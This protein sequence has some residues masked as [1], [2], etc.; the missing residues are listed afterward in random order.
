MLDDRLIKERKPAGLP[1]K[2][3]MPDKIPSSTPDDWYT[4]LFENSPLPM[5]IYDAADGRIL[6]ANR[7]ACRRYGYT[8]QEFL[9]M[10]A[11]DLVPELHQ[12]VP[13]VPVAAG[14]LPGLADLGIRQQPRKDGGSLYA[15]LFLRDLQ[16][17]GHPAKCLMAL[18]TGAAAAAEV[19]RQQQ[20]LAEILDTLPLNIYLKNPTGE[21]VLLNEQAAQTLG[22]S[23][24]ELIGK[25]AQDVLPP[26]IAEA[27]SQS[28]AAVQQAAGQLH[29]EE[30]IT[31]EE[32]P[33]TMLAG[34][35]ILQEAGEQPFLLSYSIDITERKQFEQ[36]VRHLANY[37]PLTNLPN[38]NLLNDRLAQAVAHAH[39]FGRQ[40]AV[41]FI[42]IDRFKLVNDSLGHEQGDALLKIMAAR[43][44]KALPEGD[45]LAR[46]AGDDFAATLLDIESEERVT[47]TAQGL[48]QAIAQPVQLENHELVIS[49]SIGISLYPRDGLTPH[50]LL[51]NADIAMSQCKSVGGNHFRF[52]AKEMNAR[53]F[54]RLLLETDLR[55]ALVKDEFVLHYQPKVAL[56]TGRIVGLEALIRWQH[57]TRGLLYPAKFI[58]VA[59]EIGLIGAL[60]KWVLARACAQTQ[61]WRTEGLGDFTMSVNLSARQLA[62]QN[63]LRTIRSVLDET[64]LPA[65]QLELE[66][67]ES[68]LMDNIE[69]AAA[70]LTRLSEMGV[71]L[72]ID[73]F[74]TGYSSLNY[75]KRLP[76]DTLKVDQSFIRDVSSDPDDAIIVQATIA[77]A[78]NMNLRVVAEGVMTVAQLDFLALHHCDEI[79][80]FYF[81]EPLPAFDIEQM[82]RED[83]RLTMPRRV[84]ADAPRPWC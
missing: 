48:L 27:V 42:N 49:A 60:G 53:V 55:R 18:E 8:Q 31:H 65:R 83:R 62:S 39:R 1:D 40:V 57:P 28:D 50:A 17:L 78:Q 67:T 29:I 4:A 26:E 23:K 73:D 82:L 43:L 3:F 25:T 22:R 63:L 10:R 44:Q 33:R 79:Q 71:H 36:K 56:D 16:F 2:E 51:K 54:E 72:S 75:L 84:P 11:G 35:K 32:K 34:K 74:G 14:P 46:L 81:S 37:D 59:E 12:A 13:M 45:T 41:L 69:M 58:P 9:A 70:T 38:R 30:H 80:G 7:E 47:A 64:G 77:M 76:I 5:W 68:S 66:I 15:A 24:E 19:D 52:Y 61:Q 20:L 6:A 21:L